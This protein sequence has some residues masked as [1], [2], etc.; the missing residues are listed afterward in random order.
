MTGGFVSRKCRGAR[1]FAAESQPPTRPNDLH[2]RNSTHR[3]PSA[4]HSSHALGV[5][6]GGNFSAV[7]P[8]MCS[9]AS[10][11]NI[12]CHRIAILNLSSVTSATPVICIFFSSPPTCVCI[13]VG[14]SEPL[15]CSRCNGRSDTWPPYHPESASEASLRYPCPPWR[16]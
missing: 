6:G 15:R 13:S 3:D 14:E 9:H 8:L 12:S 1:F 10:A 5:F 4:R 11:I 7:S 2:S 16:R